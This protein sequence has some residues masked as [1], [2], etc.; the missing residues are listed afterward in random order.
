MS[1]TLV[2]GGKQNI[3]GTV[4]E[5]Q[6]F[7]RWIGAFLIQPGSDVNNDRPQYCLGRH[8]FG[9]AV[10]GQTT[11]VRFDARPNLRQVDEGLV[12]TSD[13]RSWNLAMIAL[14]ARSAPIVPDLRRECQSLRYGTIG[15]G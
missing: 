4:G 1:R 9:P 11:Q 14:P 15:A 8:A 10:P 6:Q 2:R 13:H 12:D 5:L 7:D 3:E